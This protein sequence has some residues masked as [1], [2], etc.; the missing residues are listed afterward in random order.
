MYGGYNGVSSIRWAGQDDI[1]K[2]IEIRN[3]YIE[4]DMLTDRTKEFIRNRLG[5]SCFVAY[6]ENI[7]IAIMDVIEIMPNLTGMTGKV[8]YIQCVYVKKQYRK[9]GVATELIK[10]LQRKGYE[11]ELDY[12]EL[13]A[14]RM[15]KP[16]Y[17]KLGFTQVFNWETRMKF[18]YVREDD[19]ET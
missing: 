3:E 12:L 13:K 16:L 9:R 19:L 18:I 1:D 6:C 14:S 4:T 7:G 8:G 17:R 5:K 15:G 2:V 10:M 11:L